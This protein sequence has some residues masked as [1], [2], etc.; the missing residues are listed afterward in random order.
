M[1][2]VEDANSKT[3]SYVYDAFGDLLTVTDPSLHTITNTFDLRGEEF[4]GDTNVR[5]ETGRK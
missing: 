2:S 5:R 3:T 1:A 4:Y